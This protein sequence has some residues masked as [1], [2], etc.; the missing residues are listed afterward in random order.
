MSFEEKIHSSFYPSKEE[1]EFLHTQDL[2]R[3]EICERLNISI[4][5]YKKLRRYYQIKPKPRK[6]NKEDYKI[7]SQKAAETLLQRYG[8]KNSE[9]WKEF[10]E[11][12]RL[13]RENTCIEKYGVA[14]PSCL[15]E[16]IEKRKK[17]FLEKYGVDNPMKIDEFLVKAQ[18]TSFQKYGTKY[19][20][21]APEVRAK[22]LQSNIERYGT[23]YPSSLQIVIEK[24]NKTNIEKYGF[25]CALSNPE[26]RKK[27]FESMSL[28]GTRA[29]LSSRQQEYINSL[30]QGQLNYLFGYYHIDSYIEKDNI[31]IEYSG[32]GH[33]L[34]VR[35]GRE[36]IE[37][38]LGKEKARKTYFK[39]HQLPILEFFSTTDK[40]PSDD[41]LIMYY[42]Q[43]KEKFM[44]GILYYSV[45]L[46][47]KEIYYE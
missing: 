1:L 16:I 6:V 4:S 12:N 7:R 28:S 13:K 20:I 32:A 31:G 23:P 37:H 39:N 41:V 26:I 40:L 8:P 3:E 2:N 45:N 19:H 27:G 30:F 25:T 18:K 36:S 17:T 10:Q 22:I 46:D 38:F 44:N 42:N 14:D 33:D 35:L 15:P 21:A 47:N 11:A 34:S 24:R 9:T 29:V 5:T 43:A